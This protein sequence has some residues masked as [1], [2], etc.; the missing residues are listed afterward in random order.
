MNLLLDFLLV[1]L[2]KQ[3]LRLVELLLLVHFSNVDALVPLFVV[4]DLQLLSL[5][6]PLQ[7]CL[8]CLEIQQLL[9]ERV[10]LLLFSEVLLFEVGELRRH[11]VAFGPQVVQFSLTVLNVAV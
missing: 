6:H 1:K 8:L 4:D 3:E 9:G 5:L 7:L 11:R 10:D 2:S